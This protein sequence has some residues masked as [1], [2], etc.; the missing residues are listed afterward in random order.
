MENRCIYTLKTSLI[1]SYRRKHKISQKEFGA[2]LGG[3]KQQTIARWE[4][5]LSFP[6]QK[7]LSLIADRL[8]IDIKD[9]YSIDPKVLG[10]IPDAS[11]DLVLILLSFRK[12]LREIID[13]VE[14]T[15]LEMMRILLSE[16]EILINNRYST[17][18][19]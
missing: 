7:N 17:I 9:L 13:E 11:E 15:D 1:R 6:D 16:C 2:Q 18:T 8:S 19:E 4:R 12:R 10:S 14:L 3:L 5:G